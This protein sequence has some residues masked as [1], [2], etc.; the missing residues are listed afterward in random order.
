MVNRIFIFLGPSLPLAQAR[1]VLDAT[2]L[3]PASMGDVYHLI[4]EKP[5]AIAIIDGTFETHP[6][7][8]HK[9]ILHA[10]SAGIPVFGAASMGALR[11]AEMDDFGMTGVGTIYRAFRDGELTRDDEVA[12]IH[13]PADC[14][15]Q[16]LSEALVNIRHGLRLARQRG[17]MSEAQ[18]NELVSL[19][20]RRFYP[21]RAWPKLLD[22][23]RRA[24]V[25]A[26]VLT[27]L[28]DF[29]QRERP[30]AKRDDAL[31]LLRFLAVE[32]PTRSL[33]PSSRPPPAAGFGSFVLLGEHSGAFDGPWE[34]QR[35][36]LG[37]DALGTHV[38]RTQPDATALFREALRLHC[39]AQE[40]W[41][42]GLAPNVFE[43]MRM[44]S[45]RRVA[46]AGAHEVRDELA[47]RILELEDAMCTQRRSELFPLLR[48]VLTLKGRLEEVEEDC[49]RRYA[50]EG[51][52]TAQPQ[53]TASGSG[54]HTDA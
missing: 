18:E 49:A 30:D 20:A 3:P 14:G 23:A 54:R 46:G 28:R 47:A 40:A 15:H 36:G 44:V 10:L 27:A 13:A 21:E 12:V 16:P 11:A 9:E 43:A 39:L 26:N 1:Q 22:D 8:W 25:D 42:L 34:P 52:A 31:A 45:P 53:A 32:R 37:A 33:E 41:R 29:V 6:A 50:S 48:S 19:A 4:D 38:G 17:M 2:Y 35:A 5:D 7:V 51:N 24:G